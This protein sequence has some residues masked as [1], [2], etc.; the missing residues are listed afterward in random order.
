[1]GDAEAQVRLAVVRALVR[2]DRDSALPLIAPLLAAPPSRAGI[3]AARTIALTGGASAGAPMPQ[4]VQDARAYLAGAL[5]NEDAS[6]RSQAAV[7]LVSLPAHEV[8]D[9]LLIERLQSESDPGV[10]LGLA[11]AL[12][13]RDVGGAEADAVLEAL[14]EGDG[15]PAV[16]A[17]A[18]LS[19][20]GREAALARLEAALAADEPM[21]RRVA[22][23]ALARDAGRP[24]SVRH[25]M[26]DPDAMVR[27]HAAGGILAASN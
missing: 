22:A 10:R 3:E 18:I 16:Q 8:T 1:M 26:R 19:V 4:D 7:A 20:E 13:G 11:R 14:L 15:M 17:A 21:F 5:G 25:A 24:D 12:Q 23:R 27:I 2:A 6:L 9:R